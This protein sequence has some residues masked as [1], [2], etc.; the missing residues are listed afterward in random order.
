MITVVLTILVNNLD[1]RE[2]MHTVTAEDGNFQDGLSLPSVLALVQLHAPSSAVASN[3]SSRVLNRAQLR[4]PH[5][6]GNGKISRI[7]LEGRHSER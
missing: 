5:R 1:R 6:L 2:C 3:E 4:G 7:P